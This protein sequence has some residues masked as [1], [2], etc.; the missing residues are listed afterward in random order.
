MWHWLKSSLQDFSQEEQRKD[1]KGEDMMMEKRAA[2]WVEYEFGT[3]D[4]DRNEMNDGFKFCKLEE[5]EKERR[6]YLILKYEKLLVGDGGVL[7]P[8]WVID[9]TVKAALHQVVESRGV[10]C[11]W[12]GGSQR[13]KKMETERT[14]AGVSGRVQL[15]VCWA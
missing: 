6:K 4:K 5:E 1:Y 3:K 15:K 12:G 11:V 2:L 10:L 13:E 7:K 8:T 9:E 14:S